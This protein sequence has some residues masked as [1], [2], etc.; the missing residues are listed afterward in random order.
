LI[1]ISAILYREGDMTASTDVIRRLTDLFQKEPC[2]MIEPLSRRMDYSIPSMRRFLAQT[3]YYSSFT[4][5]G[6]WYTLASIPRFSRDG[7]WFYRD[8]GFSRA[9]SLTRTLVALIDASR[10]GMS[11]GELGQKLHCR[12]HG[13][14]VDLWRQGLIQR[15]RSARAHVYLSCDAQT[16]DAQRRAMA[17]SVSTVLPAEI[18]VLVLAEFIRQPSAEAAELARRV[19]AKTAVRIRADQIR[20]LFESH[21]LKKRRWGCH[22]R[23]D[24]AQRAVAP[25]GAPVGV[26]PAAAGGRF[27]TPGSALPLRRDP[28]GTK[29]KKPSA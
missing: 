24:P 23:F 22:R 8:I 7:L 12:C 3:G 27:S 15:Q 6:R 4:H 25:G 18:A 26:V 20:A 14:L 5:N 29:D 10:A 9:G 19:S 17:P 13:V 1:G 16:A 28:E 2:W 11:A 21:G